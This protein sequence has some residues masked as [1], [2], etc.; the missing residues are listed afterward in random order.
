MIPGLGKETVTLGSAPDNDVVLQGPGV[1][2][3]HARI[4]RQGGQLYFF[5]AGAAPSAANGVPA[6]P[7]QPIPFDFRT[8]F[9]LGQTPVPLA[10][11]AIAM[12]LMAPGTLQTQRGHIVVGREAARA[13]IV[14][15]HPA[16]SAQHATV[17]LDRM[18][19]ADSGSTS[20]TY[21]GGQ[22]IPANQPVP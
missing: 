16:V 5:D 13:S 14:L 4:V 15:A 12:M 3:H 18:M 21:V 10:H 19:V 1:A 22:R 6:S 17:M 8:Q 2:P 11:P 7:N 20:G 9:T